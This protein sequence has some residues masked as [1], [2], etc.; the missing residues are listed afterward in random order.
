VLAVALLIATAPAGCGDGASGDPSS[1][2]PAP[3]GKPT[4]HYFAAVGRLDDRLAA[5]VAHAKSKV[6][7]ADSEIEALASLAELAAALDDSG[8]ELGALTPPGKVAPMQLQAAIY[9]RK[10]VDQLRADLDQQHLGHA[11]HDAAKYGNR[12]GY[13]LHAITLQ[14]R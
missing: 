12:A 7:S 14:V 10:G 6:N 11:E 8:R 13:V 5:S 1:S 2:A 3:R 4:P 9:L